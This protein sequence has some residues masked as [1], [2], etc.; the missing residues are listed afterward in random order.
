M[1]RIVKE[2]VLTK[3]DWYARVLTGEFGNSLPKFFSW[4]EWIADPLGFESCTLW[5]VQHT[6][7]PG[8]P[9][10]RLNVNKE[11]VGKVICANFP[12]KIDYCISP[13]I[14]QFGQVLWEG[15]VMRGVGG[16]SCHGHANPQPGSWRKH[17]VKPDVWEGSAAIALLRSVLNGNSYDDLA[18]LLDSYPDHT[19]ELS[20]LGRCY[21]TVPGRNAVIWECRLY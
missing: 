7:I 21:G 20:A 18:I 12:G 3:A 4:G 13:M 15:D 10:T 6:S 14:H 2:P 9:G 16:V 17:M 5:G 1:S 8:F 11:D 19:V